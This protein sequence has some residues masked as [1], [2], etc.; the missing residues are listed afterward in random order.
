LAFLEL[1]LWIG[2]F[3]LVL[4]LLGID[5]GVHQKQDRALP[6]REALAW[7]AFYVT[8]A[9]AFSAFVY[10]TYENNWIEST[11]GLREDLTGAEAALSFFTA[12]LLEWS[13]ALDNI[14]VIALIFTYFG[15]PAGQ[16]HRVLFWGILGALV[17]RALMILAG[18]ALL[19]RFEWI[20]YLFG[21]LLL[22][23]AVRLLVARHDN[24]T[25]HRNIFVRICRR[26][27]AMT[28]DYRGS[29]FFLREGGR[30]HATPLA[31]ALI[32]V[33]STDLLFAV[34]SIP[35]AFA[36]TTDPFL[37]F[38]SNIFA[39][40]GLRAL[41]FTLAALLDRFRFLKMS[42][43]FVLA[44]VGVKFILS[45]HFHIPAFVSLVVV[46]GFLLV[47]VLA[48]VLHKD[49]APLISPLDAETK[50]PAGTSRQ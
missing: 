38:T 49:T 10:L 46:I 37:V 7:T 24:L 19:R 26:C 34:D 3:V 13:L 30:I 8:L 5:L 6:V 9:V 1:L 2:F 33:E 41:Y 32:V 47:G 48:S 16:Q 17:F 21:A 12:W 18:V 4:V 11:G 40:L 20:V 15:V 29:A 31:L 39:V 36:I 14:L 44:F 27:F 43:V 25:P 28:E 23:T 22:A 45:P 42:L 35:A 50:A